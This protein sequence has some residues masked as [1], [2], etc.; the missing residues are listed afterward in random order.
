MN[1]SLCNDFKIGQHGLGTKLSDLSHMPKFQDSIPKPVIK[2]KRKVHIGKCSLVL[3]FSNNLNLGWSIFLITK[4]HR[5][6][7][8]SSFGIYVSSLTYS[9]V[10]LTKKMLLE[11]KSWGI[12]F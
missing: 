6:T 3:S 1:V 2:S 9:N 7:L 10:W 4:I 11:L 8:K 12:Y 5:D